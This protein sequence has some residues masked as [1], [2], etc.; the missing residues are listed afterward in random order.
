[1]AVHSDNTSLVTLLDYLQHFN[2]SL[3]DVSETR[4]GIVHRLDKMTEGL[5]VVAKTVE[6]FEVLKK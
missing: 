4:P 5:M 6:A 2:M 3:A 1:M